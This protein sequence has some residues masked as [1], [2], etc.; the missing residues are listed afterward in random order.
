MAAASW[1]ENE[2]NTKVK[3]KLW[4]FQRISQK[5]RVTRVMKS[6]AHVLAGGRRRRQ[7]LK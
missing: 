3:V 6:D 1:N 7:R 4:K 2:A 5:F